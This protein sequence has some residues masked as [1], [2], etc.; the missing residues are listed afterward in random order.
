MRGPKQARPI[1]LPPLGRGS[2]PTA[3]CGSEHH[4]RHGVR[5]APIGQWPQGAQP[6]P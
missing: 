2:A 3:R 4:A 6:A 5:E 1:V